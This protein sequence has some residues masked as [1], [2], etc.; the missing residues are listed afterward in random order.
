MLVYPASLV[1]VEM[2]RY[3][4][5]ASR[6]WTTTVLNCVRTDSGHGT[7]I[8][9]VIEGP[10]QFEEYTLDL[11]LSCY[12]SFMKACCSIELMHKAFLHGL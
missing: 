10:T 6:K 8:P 1:I 3:H 7:R 5:K 4:N 2:S 12:L 9:A 11:A